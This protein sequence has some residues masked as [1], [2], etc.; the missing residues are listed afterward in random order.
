MRIECPYCGSRDSGEFAYRG[1]AKPSR[2]EGLDPDA[3]VDYVYLRDNV[4]G[5]IEEHWYHLNGCRQW[6][7]VRRDTLTHEISS[8]NL[9]QERGS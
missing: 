8:S 1:D 2:P 6:L 4:A 9:A 5:V 3:F 7:K